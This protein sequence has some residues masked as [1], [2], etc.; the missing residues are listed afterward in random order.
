MQ[1]FESLHLIGGVLAP[2]PLTWW[3]IQIDFEADYLYW[4]VRIKDVWLQTANQRCCSDKGFAQKVSDE[5][6]IISCQIPNKT[7]IS[8]F[9]R[10]CHVA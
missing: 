8:S 1:V 7:N 4:S 5:N 6:T 3:R 10:A 9:S 2:F